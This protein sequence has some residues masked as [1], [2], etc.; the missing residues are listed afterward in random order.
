[1]TLGLVTPGARGFFICVRGPMNSSNYQ[2]LSLNNLVP[3]LEEIGTT[4]S[5]NKIM[6]NSY[7]QTDKETFMIEVVNVLPCPPKSPESNIIKNIWVHMEH[8]ISRVQPAPKNVDQLQDVINKNWYICT[9]LPPEFLESLYH[10]M[11]KRSDAFVAK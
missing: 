9:P 10:S 11:N 2:N 8:C 1:M 4:S 3:L 7:V 6:P 5:F